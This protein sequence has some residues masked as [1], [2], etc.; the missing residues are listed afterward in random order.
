MKKFII[1]LKERRDRKIRLNTEI[2]PKLGPV[3]YFDAYN[4]RTYDWSRKDSSITNTRFTG[5]PGW[6][7]PFTA[8]HITKGE[9]GCFA[10]HYDLWKVVA[11]LGEPCIIFEDDIDIDW[12]LWNEKHIYETMMKREQDI[13]LLLLGYNENKPQEVVKHPHYDDII[14]P[15]Y[16]YNSHAYV[17][18]HYFAQWCVDCGINR[19]VIPADEFIADCRNKYLKNIRAFDKQWVKQVPREI[20]SSN[21][22]PTSDQDYHIDYRIHAVTVGTDE[23]KTSKLMTSATMNG[24]NVTN[25]GLGQ[26]WTGGNMDKPGGGMKI[27]LLRDYL[28]TVKSHEIVVFTDAYDV[29]YTADLD[30]IARRFLDFKVDILFSAEKHIWPDKSLADKFPEQT[31]EYRFLNSGTF[32]GTAGAIRSLLTKELEDT[33]DDQLYYQKCFLENKDDSSQIT[34]SMALDTEQYIFTTYDEQTEVRGNQVYNPKTQ[35]F[36]CVYHGNGGEEAKKDFTTKYTDIYGSDGSVFTINNNMSF[37]ILDKDMLL[38]DFMTQ[39]Q[40][41]E[42]IDIADHHGGWAPMEGDKFPAYEI[43]IRE[44]GLWDELLKKWNNEVVPTV[45][46]YWWPLQMYGLRDAFVMRYSVDTQKSL[47]M[48]NDASLVTGSVK[49]NSNY[50]GASLSFPRQNI[51]NDDIQNGKIILFPG[52]VTHGHECTTLT[53]GLK[54][55]FTIWSSRFSGDEN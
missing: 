28:Q 8:R 39:D 24:I 42:L 15:A 3:E 32:V 27:R 29:F 47:P 7:D 10:S 4:G 51:N 5:A 41:D 19:E 52:M 26:E 37:E 43:R 2:V 53:E 38:M 22:E 9:M 11:A 55:S 48:H 14:I 1:N 16:P 23:R 31:T 46:K 45:E 18:S 13:S 49:L 17:I 54:Y 50:K 40:C 35:C 44:L 21:V 6:R 33:D 12:D 36:G 30:T 34:V 20:S 25:L